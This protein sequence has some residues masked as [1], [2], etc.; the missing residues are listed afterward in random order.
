MWGPSGSERGDRTGGMLPRMTCGVG[1]EAS[2]WVAGWRAVR[3]VSPTSPFEGHG[4]RLVSKTPENPL[5][6]KN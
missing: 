1:V 3:D 4:D 6:S 2:V 5:N